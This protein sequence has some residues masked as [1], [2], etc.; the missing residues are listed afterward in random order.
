MKHAVE[1]PLKPQAARFAR[2]AA[3]TPLLLMG[4]AFAGL[5]CSALDDPSVRDG[6]VRGWYLPLG[7]LLL[8]L[9]AGARRD[10]RRALSLALFLL[11]AGALAAR[12]L[13]ARSASPA[14]GSDGARAVVSES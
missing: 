9:R 3:V 2:V 10:T 6:A 4:I 14:A 13:A 7:L 12:A 8:A 1:P 11:G 5:A